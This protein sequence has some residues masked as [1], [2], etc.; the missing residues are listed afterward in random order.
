M[1]SYDHIVRVIIR[2]PTNIRDWCEALDKLND[3]KRRLD[4]LQMAAKQGIIPQ[5]VFGYQ[6]T[7][8]DNL[9]YQAT[10][11]A[12]FANPDDMKYFIENFQNL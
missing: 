4:T 3:A 10:R 1:A 6:M 12:G 8:I 2:K 11:L 9:I 7:E 5:M